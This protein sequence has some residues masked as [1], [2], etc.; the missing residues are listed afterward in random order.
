MSV[1]G[2]GENYVPFFPFPA[3]EIL[4]YDPFSTFSDLW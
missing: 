1:E 3:P 2:G 4:N